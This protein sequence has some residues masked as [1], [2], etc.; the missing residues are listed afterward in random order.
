MTIDKAALLLTESEWPHQF[1]AKAGDWSR[2]LPG[3][4]SQVTLL[5]PGRER[6]EVHPCSLV[7]PSW[8][9][10]V[11]SQ[12]SFNQHGDLCMQGRVMGEQQMLGT[13]CTGWSPLGMLLPNG[14]CLRSTGTASGLEAETPTFPAKVPEP[15]RR[16]CHLHLK[17]PRPIKTELHRVLL[18][19]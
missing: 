1:P 19:N 14:S 5:L 4:L 6:Q 7:A 17:H 9:E 12:G 13:L 11:G 16:E 2:G 15:L 3:I 8:Q 10:R 18:K